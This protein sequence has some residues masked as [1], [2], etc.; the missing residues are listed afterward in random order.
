[1]VVCISNNGYPSALEV[2]K[3][4]VLL[5]DPVA[6]RKGFLRVIDESGEDYLHPKI[7]FRPIELSRSTEKAVLAAVSAK[8]DHVVR[9]KRR[10]RVVASR[11]FERMRGTA[12]TGMTTEQIMALTRS[13]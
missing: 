4:Y 10:R 5:D 11:R 7:M 12:T 2:R 8:S 9:S 6:A 13:Q 3:I 1:L